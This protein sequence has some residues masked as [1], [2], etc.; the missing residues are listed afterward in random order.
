MKLY[1][2]IPNEKR[3]TELEYDGSYEQM[4]QHISYPILDHCRINSEG[5]MIFVNDVGLLDNT[6]IKDGYFYV[7]LPSTWIMLVGEALYWGTD[8]RGENASPHNTLEQ[9]ENIISWSQP[10]G[11]RIQ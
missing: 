10:P 6:A 5:D 8:Y 7:Q 9:V 11:V 1:K 2:I 3:I 4:R